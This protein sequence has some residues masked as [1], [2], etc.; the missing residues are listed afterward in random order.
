MFTKINFFASIFQD[1]D[2]LL[3][4]SFV[5]VILLRNINL[6]NE[7]K[8]RIYYDYVISNYKRFSSISIFACETTV[9]LNINE[10]M[11]SKS[12]AI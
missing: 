9:C 11:I 5:F 3:L 1:F 12:I 4:V 6:I 10:D 2:D 7:L 8:L